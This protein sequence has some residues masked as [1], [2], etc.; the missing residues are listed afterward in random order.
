M[1][2]SYQPVTQWD[3]RDVTELLRVE[4]DGSDCFVA[5]HNQVN[6]NGAV[7]PKL[8]VQPPGNSGQSSAARKQ[9]ATLREVIYDASGLSYFMELNN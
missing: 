5:R 9:Q 6:A 2:S 3:Q 8:T 7:R 1:S 4:P